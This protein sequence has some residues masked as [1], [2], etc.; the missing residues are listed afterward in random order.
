MP[1]SLLYF[2]TGIVKR[3]QQRTGQKARKVGRNK[4]EES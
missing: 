4:G 2:A 1:T 3:V